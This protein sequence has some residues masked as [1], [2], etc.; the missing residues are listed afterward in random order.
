[1]E[2]LHYRVRYK[3]TSFHYI[4]QWHCSTCFKHDK[5]TSVLQRSI[6][7]LFNHLFRQYFINKH[8]DKHYG[9]MIQISEGPYWLSKC[10]NICSKCV[11][12][13]ITIHSHQ[14][15]KWKYIYMLPKWN[16]KHF[17]PK[18]QCIP[19]EYNDGMR[20][21]WI[22]LIN[23]CLKRNS[24]IFVHFGFHAPQEMDMC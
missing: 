21:K 7:L 13:V 5:L 14:P 22:G 6:S 11:Y 23:W 20:K 8:H 15:L 17:R 24:E 19:I 4:F 10:K 12:H 9:V 18:F 1:M 16:L 2:Y 3:Q